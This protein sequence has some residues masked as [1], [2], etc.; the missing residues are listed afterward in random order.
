[1]TEGVERY[2]AVDGAPVALVERSLAPAPALAQLARWAAWL[3]VAH[4]ADPSGAPPTLEV[5][6]S[7]PHGRVRFVGQVTGRVLEALVV[8][9]RTLATGQ[10]ELDTP[11][12]AEIVQALSRRVHVELYVSATCAF[13]PSLMAA[14]L[15]LAATSRRVD[16]TIVRAEEIAHP[17]VRSVPTML[18]DGAMAHVGAIGEYELASLL[19]AT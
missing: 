8:F 10:V 13:C 1:M 14:A 16:V 3:T 15:R 6:G 7:T 17:A 18:L 5:H 11:A 4:D 2:L 9:L 19:E 12:S